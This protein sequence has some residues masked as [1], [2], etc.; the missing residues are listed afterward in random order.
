MYI[1]PVSNRYVLILTSNCTML[2]ALEVW[3]LNLRADGLLISVKEPF[4]LLKLIGIA[5]HL[6]FGCKYGVK[7]ILTILHDF[8]AVGERQ[9]PSVSKYEELYVYAC[10]LHERW[11]YVLCCVACMSL[12]FYIYPILSK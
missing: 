10:L 4:C 6:S 11:V 2:Y 3:H 1:Q 5:F 12:S 8:E 9:R 7:S